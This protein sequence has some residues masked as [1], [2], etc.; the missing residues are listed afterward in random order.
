[1]LVFK[2]ISRFKKWLDLKN[3]QI[4]KRYLYFIKKETTTTKNQKRKRDTKN[5]KEQ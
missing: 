3:V 5:R 2:K 1:M 4:K